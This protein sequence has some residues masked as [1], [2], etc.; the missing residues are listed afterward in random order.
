MQTTTSTNEPSITHIWSR[1]N[2]RWLAAGAFSGILA[3][4]LVIGIGCL[5]A[6]KHMGEWSQPFKIIGAAIYGKEALHFGAFGAAGMAGLI[7]HVTLSAIYGST[8]A[9]M[10]NENSSRGALIILGAV[11]SMIIWV[12][13]CALFMPAFDIFL[14]ISMPILLGVLLHI[15]FGISFGVILGIVRPV[16]IEERK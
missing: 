5:L 11:T 3:G 4:L 2:P 16:F 9:Q 14:R 7:I 13:G 15:I 6:G 10:V 1:F 8:F 12:F